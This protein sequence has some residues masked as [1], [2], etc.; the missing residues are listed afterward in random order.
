MKTKGLIK[1]LPRDRRPGYIVGE[2]G[3]LVVFYE[4]SLQGLDPAGLFPGDWVEYEE[5]NRDEGRRAF[6]IMPMIRRAEE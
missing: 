1:Q 3:R 4:A 2:N 5:V 6:G